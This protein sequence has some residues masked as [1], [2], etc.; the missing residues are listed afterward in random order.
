M[1]NRAT[2]PLY[3]ILMLL[4][5]NEKLLPV[6][7]KEQKVCEALEPEGVQFA[8]EIR[9]APMPPRTHQRFHY[10]FELCPL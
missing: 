2:A 10:A 7:A 8:P 9:K 3:E 5:I 1:F 4:I 6:W